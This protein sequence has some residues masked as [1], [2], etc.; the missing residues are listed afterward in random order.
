MNEYVVRALQKLGFRQRSY[1][2]V[3]AQGSPGYLALLDLARYSR[4]F[5]PDTEGLSDGQIR[6]MHG[7]RQMFFRIFINVKLSPAELEVVAGD[8]IVSVAARLQRQHGESE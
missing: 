5:E 7:R 2:Q 8:A 4:A 1:Q 3:F 6:E